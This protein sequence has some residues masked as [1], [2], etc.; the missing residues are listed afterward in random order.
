MSKMD[1][2]RSVREFHIAFGKALLQ[3]EFSSM[4]MEVP[5]G[6][7]R[8]TPDSYHIEAAKTWCR[9]HAKELREL[10]LVVQQAATSGDAHV[11]LMMNFND[12]VGGIRTF[13]RQ[14]EPDYIYN[15]FQEGLKSSGDKFQNFLDL[16]QQLGR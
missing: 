2:P 12:D 15:L 10:A 7:M 16:L 14:A 13:L 9:E 1:I 6:A 5:E 11:N 8:A 4:H 3:L